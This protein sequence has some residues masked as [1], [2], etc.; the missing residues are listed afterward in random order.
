VQVSLYE[1][2]ISFLD[3]GKGMQDLSVAVTTL[4]NEGMPSAAGL[5]S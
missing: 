1:F 4:N 3:F 2:P 5:M